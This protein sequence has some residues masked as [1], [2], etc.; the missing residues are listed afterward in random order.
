MAEEVFMYA[1]TTGFFIGLTAILFGTRA[2]RISKTVSA[3]TGR[4]GGAL[5][6]T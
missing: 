5:G 4:S 1:V 3:S 2:R 6:G